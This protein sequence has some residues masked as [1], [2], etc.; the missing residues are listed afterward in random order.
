MTKDF[1][2]NFFFCNN[3]NTN[4]TYKT[5]KLVLSM[6]RISLGLDQEKSTCENPQIISICTTNNKMT[7]ESNRTTQNVQNVPNFQSVNGKK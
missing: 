3:V 7:I 1:G 4:A 2:L 6:C 5:N